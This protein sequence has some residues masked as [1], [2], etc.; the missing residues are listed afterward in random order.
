MNS[1][2][3][4]SKTLCRPLVNFM[5][6]IGVH[7]NFITFLSLVCGLS[8]LFFH[9][10]RQYWV[11]ASLIVLRTAFDCIDGEVARECNKMSK[12]GSFFDGAADQAFYLIT[13]TYIFSD[14][15]RAPWALVIGIAIVLEYV[16]F[17]LPSG[18]LYNAFKAATLAKDGRMSGPAPFIINN[19]M[20]I[21]VVLSVMYLTY[22]MVIKS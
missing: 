15:C 17:V 12:F 3:Y 18:E 1:D 22:F 14:A 13:V 2:A 5:C 7:P 10:K 8:A 16:T 20:L 6:K 19:T 4:F 9:I 11:V 21:F